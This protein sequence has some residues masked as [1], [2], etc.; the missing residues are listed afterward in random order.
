[1]EKEIKELQP[2]TIATKAI[3]FILKK[4]RMM[5][6]C[7]KNY[8]GTYADNLIAAKQFIADSD[9]IVLH[10]HSDSLKI[11][12]LPPA[13]SEH[14]SDP[15]FVELLVDEQL[16]LTRKKFRKEQQAI[17]FYVENNQITKALG[18]KPGK[19]HYQLSH[20]PMHDNAK[21][22]AALAQRDKEENF[23]KAVSK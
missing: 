8:F 5:F 19:M 16:R 9:I 15:K 17:L 11:P 18:F 4:I 6:L 12:I 23:L 22:K 7:S 21:Y 1:M 3:D 13:K 20:N 14:S 10:Y 2:P